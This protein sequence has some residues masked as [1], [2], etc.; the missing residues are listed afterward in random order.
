MFSSLRLYL[1][2]ALLGVSGCRKHINDCSELVLLCPSGQILQSIQPAL[3]RFS[4]ENPGISVRIISSPAKDY[5]TKTLSLLAAQQQVDVL[6]IGQGL[7]MFAGRNTLLP[8]D[9]MLAQDQEISPESFSAGV[10]NLYRSKR[11]LY[12][13]PYGFDVEMLAVNEDLLQRFNVA[14]PADDW[15]MDQFVDI[16]VKA[17]IYGK[18]MRIKLHG[19]GMSEIPPGYRGLSVIADDGRQFGLKSSD[20]VDWVK[21][22]QKLISQGVLLPSATE[23]QFDRLNEFISERVAVM[24]V[25]TWEL[26]DLKNK[27]TFNWRLLPIP[28]N[29]KNTQFAW[30]STSGFSI[31]MNS[32]CPDE[33][34]RLVKALIGSETQKS[35]QKTTIPAFVSELDH[36]AAKLD[37]RERA[38]MTVIPNA[39]A[40]ARV[41][42]ADTALSEWRY[43]GDKSMQGEV[44][45]EQALKN[46]ESRI[47]KMLKDE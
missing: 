39:K 30:A 25:F 31:S 5:Y 11:R 41:K 20:A 28:R 42:R 21:T 3:Q 2:L 24:R 6:W 46:A 32:L 10:L 19:L 8:I 1:V 27:A 13:L 23:G 17:S 7:G 15:T 33:S 47:D 9:G 44:T 4:S 40:D 37:P 22:N 16:G 43:W 35:L 18:S 34:W 45:P 12:G 29:P 14:A 26:T 38:I 36:Y